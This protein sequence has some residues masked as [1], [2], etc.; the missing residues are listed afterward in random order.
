MFEKGVVTNPK[1]RP[2]GSKGKKNTE[3]AKR[4]AM[5]LEGMHEQV[6]QD[7]Q[8]LSPTDRVKAYTNLLAYAIPKQTSISAVQKIET[9]FAQLEQLLQ[10]G[11]DEAIQAIANK[12]LEM[13]Q[14]RNEQLN[15]TFDDGKQTYEY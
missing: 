11:S 4:V 3:L 14:E 12:V 2:K 13:Q 9:E 8:S 7:I 5:L 1:G 10:N 6:L 15:T